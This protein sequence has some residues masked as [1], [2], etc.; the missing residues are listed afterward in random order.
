MRSS[1]SEWF[2]PW[3]ARHIARHPNAG[4]P[5]PAANAVL[6]EA[7]RN[8]LRRR[9]VHDAEVADEA[10]ERLMGTKHYP[11]EHFAKL[12]ELAVKVYAD[13]RQAGDL[14]VR[15]GESPLEEARRRGRGCGWC[16]GEGWATVWPR[17]GYGDERTPPHVA[18]T[19]VC[20]VGQAVRRL[21]PADLARRTP[22]LADAIEGRGAW[23]A[24]RP[25]LD[26]YEPSPETLAIFSRSRNLRAALGE[27]VRTPA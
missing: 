6:Y 1:L 16:H 19:C 15:V 4:L 10:S 5:D 14:D 25:G 21:L 3:V 2:A 24:D 20:P 26:G 8:E 9:G 27:M 22:L 12:V 7:W 18:A 13:R 17:P 23:R 11:A